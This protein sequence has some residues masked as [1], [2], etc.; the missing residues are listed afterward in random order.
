[1]GSMG[2]VGIFT[3][4][5]VYLRKHL[6]DI[7]IVVVFQIFFYGHTPKRGRFN[8]FDS[9]VYIYIKGVGSTTN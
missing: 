6:A 8:P 9:Y 3:T 5:F 2:G 7:P 1:M 4:I